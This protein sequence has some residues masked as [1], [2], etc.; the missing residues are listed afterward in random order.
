MGDGTGTT[1]V[2]FPIQ[3]I[4]EYPTYYLYTIANPEIPSLV[5]VVQGILY[6]LSLLFNAPL[7]GPTFLDFS[8]TTLDYNTYISGENTELILYSPQPTSIGTLTIPP[9]VV[10][11]SSDYTGEIGEELFYNFLKTPNTNSLSIQ[12]QV[13]N[14][15]VFQSSFNP[16]SK[17]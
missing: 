7:I 14:V 2:T 11:P 15:T 5:S 12:I 10:N 6:N 4:S 3:Q 17:C 13:S 9:Y 8:N 1:N 16:S